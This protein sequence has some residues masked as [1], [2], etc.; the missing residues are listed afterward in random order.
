M[1]TTN[2]R[3]GSVAYLVDVHFAYDINQSINHIL[4]AF[5]SGTDPI[6]LLTL[7]FFFLLFCYWGCSVVSNRVG[8]K[9]GAIVLKRVAYAS[10]GGVE[11]LM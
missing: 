6:L 1:G 3:A 8:M 4:F 9:F 2:S 5:G 11:I 7:F 10:T